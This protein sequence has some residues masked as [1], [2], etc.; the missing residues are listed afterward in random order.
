MSKDPSY[1]DSKKDVLES[2]TRKLELIIKELE[3]ENAKLKR[4]ISALGYDQVVDAV[5]DSLEK[6]EYK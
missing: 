1:S 5:I 6:L 4:F 2:K 3:A